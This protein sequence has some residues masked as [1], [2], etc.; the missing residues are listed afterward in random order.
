MKGLGIVPN[1]ASYFASAS[2]CGPALSVAAAKAIDTDGLL[3]GMGLSEAQLRDPDVL[4]STNQQKQFIRNVI[5]QF[6]DPAAGLHIGARANLGELGVLGV[7]V[8]SARTFREALQIGAKFA[9][10][11]GILGKVEYIDDGVNVAVQ[12]DFPF[13]EP[14]LLRYLAEEFFA[15]IYSY[16]A[17]VLGA[18]YT[19]FTGSQVC[20]VKVCFSHP[21]PDYS[22]VYDALFQCPVIFDA[23]LTQIWIR[24]E[25]LDQPLS[26]SNEVACSMSAALCAKLLD[27]RREENAFVVDI[28]QLL[29]EEPHLFPKLESIAAKIGLTPRTLRRRLSKAGYSYAEI[30]ADTKKKLA[31]DLLHNPALTIAEVGYI[32]GYSEVTNFRRAFKGWTGVSPSTFRKNNP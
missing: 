20:A 21:C 18:D 11:G 2:I 4:L 6:G 26:L 23:P 15:A 32:L 25:L 27:E 13:R 22:E 1:D 19:P 7:A 28:Q 10:T 12:V 14:K 16:S 5:E 24:Q 30:L 31:V 9:H 3:Q 8:L 17:L 29:V